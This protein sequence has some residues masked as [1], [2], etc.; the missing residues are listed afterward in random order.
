MGGWW[1][2]LY[3]RTAVEAECWRESAC[4]CVCKVEELESKVIDSLLIAAADIVLKDTLKCTLGPMVWKSEGV[5]EGGRG[6]TAAVISQVH[7]VFIRWNDGTIFFSLHLFKTRG[8]LFSLFLLIFRRQA[9]PE[10]KQQQILDSLLAVAALC[11]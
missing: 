7:P 2:S 10:P 1:G 5:A 8:E 11:H 6:G 3:W 9:T 4:V